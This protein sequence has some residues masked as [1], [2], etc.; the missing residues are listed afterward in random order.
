MINAYIAKGF[1]PIRGCLL[2]GAEEWTH[3]CFTQSL[4]CLSW[5][6]RQS[7]RTFEE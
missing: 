6:V 2:R 4:V 7:T 3:L 1:F 5:R